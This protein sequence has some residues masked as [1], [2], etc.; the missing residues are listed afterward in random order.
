[1]PQG[2]AS[3]PPDGPEQTSSYP[4]EIPM[5]VG[6]VPEGIEI[7]DGATAYVTSLAVGVVYRVDLATGTVDVI[8]EVG[9]M[10]AGI[11]RDPLDRLFVCGGLTGD[12]SILE[13]ATGTTVAT[14]RLGDPDAGTF[15]N[16]VLI[17]PDCAWVTDSF[18]PLLYKLPLG[19][20]G[21]L[22]A[23]GD[24][25]RLA[26][27][28]DFE[29]QQGET[30]AEGFNSNGIVFTP[31]RRALL[32]VQTNTGKLFRVD[33]DSGA[34][35][36]VDL[37]GELLLWGDG[38]LR[39][40]RLL[41]AVENVANEIAV[42]EMNEEGTSGRVIDRRT[43]PRFDTPTA[44]AR[45]GDRFYLSNARFTNPSPESADFTIVAIDA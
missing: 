11:S 41:Y 37:G 13:A 28:G 12:L 30:F 39:E 18:S 5:P 45:F 36:E 4:R 1:M 7:A 44:I 33:G 32:I 10:T 29:Y 38:L 40:D 20:R 24:V 23:E 8:S 22:P 16:D 17:G 31:D 2:Q 15:I 25:E 35:A 27:S 3:P 43:D 9:A 19:P 21:E 14:Y 42:V 26:I 6:S 34:T